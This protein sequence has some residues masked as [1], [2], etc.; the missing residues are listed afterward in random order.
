MD[1]ADVDAPIHE[2]THLLLGSIKYQNPGLYK[3]LINISEQLPSYNELIKNYQGRTRSDINEEIFV[4]E[5]AKFVTNKNSIISELPEFVQ[6][7]IL[8]NIKRLLDS[9]FMGDLSVKT[10]PNEQLTFLSFTEMA[11]LI[12]STAFNNVSRGSLDNSAMHRILNNR[13]S[14]LINNN[15]L[16]EICQ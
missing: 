2:M 7:E 4:T 10:I 16:K 5:L 11:E 14:D 13:K 15:E 12:N 1:I 6:E 3:E 9:I 8:Y